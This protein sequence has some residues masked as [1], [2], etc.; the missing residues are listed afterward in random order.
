M[1]RMT[2]RDFGRLAIAGAPLIGAVCA[3]KDADLHAQAGDPVVRS[4]NRSLIGGVQFGL[5]PFCYHDLAM[6]PE[7]RADVD[8]AARAER[9][10]HGRT[11]CHLGR[12][13]FHRLR[14]S[15]P[16]TAREK[17]RAWRLGQLRRSLRA[18]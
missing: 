3:W 2:R 12:A 15:A 10:G 16:E 6:T 9:H 1:N 14:A 8:Q 11:A 17:L 5:Q 13:A 18:S 4:G 7:N